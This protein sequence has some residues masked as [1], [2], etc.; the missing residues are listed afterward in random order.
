MKNNKIVLGVIVVVVAAALVYVYIG[1]GKGTM[2]HEYGNTP[3]TPMEGMTGGHHS[4]QH[5][6]PREAKLIED[7]KAGGYIL[8]ARH[9][10]T[11]LGKT[12]DG[13]PINFDDCSTQRNLSESGKYSAQENGMAIKMLGVPVASSYAS[14]FCR[15]YDT[16]VAL[17]G[18]TEKVVVLSGRETATDP[19]DMQKAGKLTQE[20]MHKVQI[21]EG[22]NIAITGHWGTINLATGIHLHEGDIAVFKREDGK[23]VHMGT[24]VASTWSDVIHDNVRMQGAM[25]G[26]MNKEKMMHN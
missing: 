3:E 20:F 24:I 25:G 1:F 10:R 15:T 17:F 6:E 12:L 11:E 22:R 7:I 18:P 19:F 5:A 2:V 23:L 9:E 21:P 16:A 8:Y 4:A 13:E 26:M 14:P